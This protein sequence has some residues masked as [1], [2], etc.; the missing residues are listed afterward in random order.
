MVRHRKVRWVRGRGW[1]FY[2]P[3]QRGRRGKYR[4]DKENR[5]KSKIGQL[6]RRERELNRDLK[7]VRRETKAVMEEVKRRQI[8]ESTGKTL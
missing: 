6:K 2:W 1:V 7:F 8:N 4:R 5:F 3:H